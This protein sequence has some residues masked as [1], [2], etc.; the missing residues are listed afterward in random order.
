MEVRKG[1][2]I[3]CE[4]TYAVKDSTASNR[5]RYCSE[6][7]EAERRLACKECRAWCREI[8][9]VADKL[10]DEYELG[11]DETCFG[12]NNFVNLDRQNLTYYPKSKRAYLAFKKRYQKWKTNHCWKES[13]W[14]WDEDSD[15]SSGSS[16]FGGGGGDGG[17]SASGCFMAALKLI[18]IAVAVWIGWLVLKGCWNGMFHGGKDEVITEAAIMEKW[19]E[20]LEKRREAFDDGKPEKEVEA[21]GLRN[22]TWD[23]WQEKFRKEHETAKEPSAVKSSGEDVSIAQT[24]KEIGKQAQ[25]TAKEIGD[26]AKGM[27]QSITSA[28][29]EKNTEAEAKANVEAEA[30][31]KAEAEAKAKAE[32]EARAK[33]EAEARAKMEAEVRAKVEAEVRAKAEKEAEARAK[34]E[35]EVRA[36]VEAEAK[37]KAV[38][39][40]R[41]KAEAE[42]KEKEDIVED[43][44]DDVVGGQQD[45][46]VRKKPSKDSKGIVTTVQGKGKT[47]D[48]ALRYAIR[49]AVFRTVGTWVGSKTRIDENREALKAQMTTLTEDD[50]SKFEVLETQQQDGMIV[51]KVKVY[52]SKKK[53]APK[54]AA[55][56]PDVFGND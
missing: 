28:K 44:T 12:Y 21:K 38:A 33:A 45:G 17:S 2:C 16:F 26:K 47:K 49:Q 7:C 6:G 32:A 35:A 9:E 41:T 10:R 4:R 15:E 40:A 19:E 51:L 54:F 43:A 18:G 29:E 46:T 24:E 14:A 34:L 52:V 31:A 3:W 20:H 1:K 36:K 30:K 22:Y 39:E 56:F 5:E 42:A 53:I 50:V 23:E 11:E 55:I 8:G 13:F 25:S 48:A 37:A 27:W